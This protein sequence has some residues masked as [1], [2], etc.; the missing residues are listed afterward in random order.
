MGLVSTYPNNPRKQGYDAYWYQ[1][2]VPEAKV[3]NPYTY[4]M[5]MSEWNW[6]WNDAR[7]EDELAKNSASGVS[8]T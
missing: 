6:G 2:R 1:N 3:F 7:K 5:P 8:E 4:D